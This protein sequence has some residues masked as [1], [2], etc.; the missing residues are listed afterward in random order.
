LRQRL[1]CDVAKPL[2]Q[3]PNATQ[4]TCHLTISRR[5][6]VTESHGPRLRPGRESPDCVALLLNLH[7]R[8]RAIDEPFRRQ[9][10]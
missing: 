3:D 8:C 7:A 1:R 9:P 10:L 6:F 2:W 5:R 4:P